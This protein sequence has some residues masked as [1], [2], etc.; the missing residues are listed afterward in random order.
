MALNAVLAAAKMRALC[1]KCQPRSGRFGAALQGLKHCT[2]TP[3]K[4]TPPSP[5]GESGGLLRLIL[6]V[7]NQAARARI[8]LSSSVSGASV[9]VIFSTFSPTA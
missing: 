2:G 8:F 7:V 1:R 4:S 6:I 9:S 5:T 3:S